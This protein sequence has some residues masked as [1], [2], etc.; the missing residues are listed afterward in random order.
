MMTYITASSI[1]KFLACQRAY[2]YRYELG[3]LPIQTTE[4]LSFGRAYH[5][6]LE[7]KNKGA[8]LEDSL[9]AGL[10]LLADDEFQQATLIGLFSGYYARYPEAGL[11][12]QPEMR[13]VQKITWLNGFRSAGV[14]DGLIRKNEDSWILKEYKTTGASVAPD[15][16][17]WDRLRFNIQLMTYMLALKNVGYNVD[18]ISYD[19]TRKPAIRPKQNETAEQFADRLKADTLERPDFYFAQRSVTVL[20]DDLETFSKMRY[21]ICQQIRF[22][23]KRAKA[24]SGCAAAWVRNCNQTTCQSCEFK[25]FCL[26]GQVATPSEIPTGFEL[27]A[28]HP[29]LQLK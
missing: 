23:R 6:C 18:E 10:V 22:L 8:S 15:S 25:N 29:E 2:Y 13:F 20:D 7:A 28:A 17:Y 9:K 12:I 21:E 11:Q 26:A 27:G 19:V 1:Q 5:A 4:A 24:C 14:I 3:L 16:E